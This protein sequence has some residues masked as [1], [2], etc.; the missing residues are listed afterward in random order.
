VITGAG[1]PRRGLCHRRS[2]GGEDA[3][4]E[5]ER[6]SSELQGRQD[7]GPLQVRIIGKNVLDAAACCELAKDS[8]RRMPAEQ[9]VAAVEECGAPMVSLAGGEPLMHPQIHEIVNELVKRRKFVVLCTNAVLMSKHL[10]KFTP[11]K[12]FAWMVHIDGLRASGGFGA[13]C[14]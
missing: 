12:N 8:T 10:H 14:G 13:S 2:G 6:R 9:A 1:T 11:S 7:V 4:L 5:V 3:A